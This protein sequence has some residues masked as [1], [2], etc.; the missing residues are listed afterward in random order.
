MLNKK[1][2]IA[3]IMSEFLFVAGGFLLCVSLYYVVELFQ[4]KFGASIALV[5]SLFGSSAFFLV[6][7]QVLKALLDTAVAAQD[8]ATR[9]SQIINLLESSK[10]E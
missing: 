7:S 10:S 1:Y 5:L 2:S 3:Y 6:S 9:A 8:T 4:G